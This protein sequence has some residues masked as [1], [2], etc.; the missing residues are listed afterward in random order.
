LP[1]PERK[2]RINR[3]NQLHIGRR[4]VAVLAPQPCDHLGDNVL[5]ALDGAE[6]RQPIGSG[7]VTQAT[8]HPDT[9]V[10]AVA[11]WCCRRRMPRDQ[12]SSIAYSCHVLAKALKTMDSKRHHAYPRSMGEAKRKQY[13]RA[14]FLRDHPTCA[15]CGGVATTTD[16]CPPRTFFV[17]RVWPEKYELPACS[18]CNEENRQDEQVVAVLSRIGLKEET[19]NTEWK[20]LVQGVRN[21]QP[22]ILAEWMPTKEIHLKRS[23]RRAF[24]PDGDRM[25]HAGWRSINI[26]PL[27]QDAI[28]RFM[29]KLAKALYYLHNGSLL[30]G[31]IYASH[32][33]SLMKAHTPQLIEILLRI[34]PL[35]PEI[36]RGTQELTDQFIY[37][38]N[39]S[40][41][42]GIMYA[43]VQFNP[44]MIFQLMAVRWDM[45]ERIAEL[46]QTNGKRMPFQNRV[47]SR[48]KQLPIGSGRPSQ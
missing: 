24:G 32:F 16:H 26:G 42:H 12:P 31:V 2:E 44:Q 6:V 40:A 3:G 9:P 20:R 23:M 18:P 46:V 25:R 30:D 8:P 34:A 22:Q 29:I 27:T 35:A 28:R 5:P 36:R 14:Q 17:G 33:N 19:V 47:E 11:K 7:P 39:H 38:F 1:S 43:V 15:Y 4:T 37:R 21:N 10:S 41:E 45:E 13:N 48:P